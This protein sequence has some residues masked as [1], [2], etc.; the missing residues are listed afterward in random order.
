M[1]ESIVHQR[2]HYEAPDVSLVQ[3]DISNSLMQASVKS[4][5]IP[6]VTEEELGWS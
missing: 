3:V 1:K 2:L 6:D 5:S 4:V